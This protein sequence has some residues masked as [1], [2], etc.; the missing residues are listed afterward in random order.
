MSKEWMSMIVVSAVVSF[1]LLTPVAQAQVD[2]KQAKK[3]WSALGKLCVQY[4]KEY[5]SQ[6][7]VQ[8]KGVAF[9]AEWE[10]WKK[11]FE[12]LRETFKSRYGDNHRKVLEFFEG[13]EKPLDMDMDAW[14][15]ANIAYDIDIAQEEGK[16]TEWAVTWGKESY[17]KW[18]FL[19]AENV[20]KLELKL[21]RAEEA[22]QYFKLAK[23]WNP[24][25]DYD[26]Y[27]EQ[28]EAAVKETRPLWEK[29]LKE[30]KWPGHNKD[31]AG[32]GN[33]DE[34]AKAAIEFLRKNPQWSKPEYDDE[35]IPVA[36]CVTAVEWEVSKKA[37]LTHEP[38]QYS[39]NVFV[40]FKGK[41]DPKIAY[42]YQMVFYTREEAGVKKEP[43]FRYANSR[44]YAKYR[45]L[46]S[47][48]PAK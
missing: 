29:A 4:Q 15:V 27:I 34:L 18:K 33:P 9:Q 48:V 39:L 17:R 14:Q 19:K 24:K 6:S 30:L 2:T 40:A 43:P 26:E 46:M 12:P 38:T 32:P 1:G 16:F 45:M 44:Q 36:A 47:N 8:K 25:G 35:H 23:T 42:C 28:A 20:E 41:K 22:L 10:A 37:P 5:M 31:F 11:Q 13:M 3:D 21:S 7:E